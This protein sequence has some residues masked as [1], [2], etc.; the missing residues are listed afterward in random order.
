MN[1]VTTSRLLIRFP[2]LLKVSVLTANKVSGINLTIQKT[3]FLDLL[4]RSHPSQRKEYS[5]AV[6]KCGYYCALVKT[7][8]TVLQVSPG[9]VLSF[10]FKGKSKIV[11]E[12]KFN[13]S[14]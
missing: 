13:D 1:D 6:S 8:K 12:V 11:F 9:N 5:M 4:A 7:L 3:A 14:C 10:S 2:L